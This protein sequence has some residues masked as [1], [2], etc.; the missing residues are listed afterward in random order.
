MRLCL[1]S[2]GQICV[3][4]CTVVLA[5]PNLW[6]ERMCIDYF[7]CTFCRS[8]VYVS[9]RVR[10]CSFVF[11]RCTVGYCLSLD[12][13][14]Q[15]FAQVY[16]VFELPI[17]MVVY[18]HRQS[19]LGYIP[20]LSVWLFTATVVHCPCAICL[21]FMHSLMRSC[22]GICA[23][24]SILCLHSFVHEHRCGNVN[25]NFTS[26]CLRGYVLARVQYTCVWMSL[27]SLLRSTS[28]YRVHKYIL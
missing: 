6:V 14:N 13:T 27:R 26:W 3:C 20:Q 16:L 2:Y 4:S 1:V 15:C 18:H 9:T 23:N 7:V 10:L 19:C 17:R 11:F 5:R 12:G 21:T 25:Q 24:L 28:K 22:V 8:S